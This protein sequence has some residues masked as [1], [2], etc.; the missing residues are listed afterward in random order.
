MPDKRYH[1]HDPT[2]TRDGEAAYSEMEPAELLSILKKIQGIELVSFNSQDN[3]FD[4]ECVLR[5]RMQD[6]L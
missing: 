5:K 4:F 1:L 2:V 6:S 3:N